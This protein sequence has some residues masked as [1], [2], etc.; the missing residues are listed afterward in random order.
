[1][2]PSSRSNLNVQNIGTAPMQTAAVGGITIGTTPIVGGIPLR[3]LYD[4]SGFVGEYSNAE[5]TALVQPFTSSLSGSVPAST[6]S[7]TEFLRGDG[8]WGPAT[9]AGTFNVLTFG[10]T[11][12]GVTNDAVAIQ[13][14]LNAAAVTGGRVYFPTGHYFIGATQLFIHNPAAS[15]RYDHRTALLG[16]GP[17]LSMILS[18]PPGGNAGVVVSGN[19]ATPNDVQNVVFSN[20]GFINPNNNQVGYGL[21][22]SQVDQLELWHC[23]FD[24]YAIGCNM[25]DCLNVTF[26][27]CVFYGNNIGL[28]GITTGSSRPNSI[29]IFNPTVF[30][31]VQYGIYLAQPSDINIY[32]GD[33]EHNGNSTAANS[34][35]YIDGNSIEGTTGV[36]IYGGYYSLNTGG[37]DIYLNMNGTLPTVHK[38]TGVEFQKVNAQNVNN[39][40]VL[41]KTGT[42]F[43]SISLDDCAFQKFGTYTASGTRPDVV[44]TNAVDTSWVIDVRNPYFGSAL[45]AWSANGYNTICNLAVTSGTIEL[46]AATDTTIARS[47]AGAIT[48]E[49]VQV[50]LSGK[51]LGTPLSGT[52][53]N[54]SGLPTTGIAAG[55]LNIG[56]ANALT[57][58]T[59]ELGTAADTTIARTGAGVINVEGVDVV[60]VSVAQTLTNKVLTAPTITTSITP[61]TDDGAALGSTA[62]KFADLFLASG[63]VLNFNSGNVTV[64]HAAGQLTVAGGAWRCAAGT[65]TLAPLVFQSGT[66]LTTAAAGVCE[67]DGSVFYHTA[68]AS[69][70]QVVDTEQFLTLSATQ[71]A[72]S[73]TVAQTWFPGGGATQVTLAASTSYFFEG[74]LHLANGATTHTTALLFAGGATLTSIKYWYDIASVAEN[75][76][77][78]AP[79]VGTNNT[80]ASTVLN[81]TSVAVGA[82]IWVRGIVRV[83]AGGTFIPQFQWSANPTGT[84]QVLQNTFFRVWPV[85]SNTVLNVGNWS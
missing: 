12:N 80:A 7:A 46:G 2:F 45:E 60:L 41:N 73:S 6:G 24:G 17:G 37:A 61:T 49:G 48:V 29:N 53:S 55:A 36:K 28:N 70:R 33:Y 83:N 30:W 13:A 63:G 67:F 69:A 39:H 15:G 50:L 47:G 58:G 21:V 35:I 43:V 82:H 74:E 40:V 27:N 16:D 52:L 25:L 1:M 79:S 59:I 85:G 57:C 68:V 22:L 78:V 81:A 31:N 38:I 65:T 5:L 26:G 66:N 34:T 3:V 72:T 18:T 56:T 77:G 23:V 42:G 19:F 64:T 84:N 8:S 54:C 62:L 76:P 75:T 10:A 51:A 9:T 4:N 71:T 11:G 44:V 32:G 20:L 14:A